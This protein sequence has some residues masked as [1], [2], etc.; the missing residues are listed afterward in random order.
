[1]LP[2]PYHCQTARGDQL[3]FFGLP[4]GTWLLLSELLSYMDWTSKAGALRY[5]TIALTP[6]ATK[7]VCH[8]TNF[9]GLVPYAIGL[10]AGCCWREANVVS[11]LDN[12]L[13]EHS[14]WALKGVTGSMRPQTGRRGSMIRIPYGVAI[15]AV[16]V[17]M[18]NMGHHT[19]NLFVSGIPM[20]CT[21]GNTPLLRDDDCYW[22]LVMYQTRCNVLSIDRCQHRTL[23]Y[24][25]SR[26]DSPTTTHTKQCTT[27]CLSDLKGRA[28]CKC[29]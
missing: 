18:N 1:M 23:T 2:P 16:S 9:W 24:I 20:D 27:R 5:A 8:N 28:Q 6:V 4:V 29:C 12:S 26:E 10:T 17:T 13:K 15:S 19:H 22:W 14:E 3:L 25:I 7:F 21:R 11:G